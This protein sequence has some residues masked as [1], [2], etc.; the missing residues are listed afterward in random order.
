MQAIILISTLLAIF[1][2]S[3][4]LAQGHY[5][6][7]PQQSIKIERSH[8]Y[9]AEGKEYEQTVPVEMEFNTGACKANL[10]LEYFQKGTDAH[11]KATL[12]NEQCGA[13]SGNY[14]VR[15][16]YRDA[17]GASKL[18]EFDENWQRDDNSDVTS[19]KEYFVGDDVDIRRIKTRN[20]SCR[21]NGPEKIEEQTDTSDLE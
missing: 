2:S 5:E 6:A 20:L 19:E 16:Q 21:C 13:S 9:K 18:L 11:V 8:E 3:S 15:V 4:S 7:N 12:Q 17:T 10:S 1:V 14:T